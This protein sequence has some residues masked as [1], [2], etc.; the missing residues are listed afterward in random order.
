[1]AG[2][3]RAVPRYK[4]VVQRGGLRMKIDNIRE[5]SIF[6]DREKDH[7]N[8][9]KVKIKTEIEEPKGHREDNNGV[10]FEKIG[11]QTTL[12]ALES[13]GM[14]I[15]FVIDGSSGVVQMVIVESGTGREV[16]RVPADSGFQKNFVNRAC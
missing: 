4:P 8:Q 9:P 13:R 14:E 15:S 12:E 11:S 5:S 1:M 3:F 7:V 16:L 2:S 6:F 10:L